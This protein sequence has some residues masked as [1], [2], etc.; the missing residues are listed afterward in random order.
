MN[1]QTFPQ[2]QSPNPQLISPGPNG[3][4]DHAHD[5]HVIVQIPCLNEADTLPVV[6]ADLPRA[7]PGV[8]RLETLVIDDG[9]TDNTVA[10]ARE[11]GVTYI[12]QHETN[13]GLAAAFQTGLDAS[14]KA[15]ADIII[16]TDGDNQYPGSKI[17]ELIRPIA[18][19]RADMVVGDRQTAGIIHFS[20]FK[21]FLQG[22]GSWVVRQASGTQVPDA[23]SGFRA[24]SREA[25]LRL[26]VL[27]RY[28][29]TAELIIQA[30]KKNLR[31]AHIPVAVNDPLRESRLLKNNWT[32]V[33]RQAATILR[34]YALYEPLRS[35]CYL[36]LPFLLTG[37]FLI[38]RFLY[39]YM[40]NQTY[41]GRHIQSVVIGGTL[42][43][44]GFFISLFGVMA[45]ITAMNR[46][47]LE[48]VLYR[49]RKRE[50][51]ETTGK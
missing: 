37:T 18:E 20:P 5:L 39:F 50:L 22:L 29:Y 11:L 42:L 6:L 38:G 49:Q 24:F 10:V 31:I 13:R 4:H 1:A 35:F 41:A 32:F 25:A 15:G 40:T 26:I 28:T 21:R 45:D 16:N 3:Y 19:G 44:V 51:S 47:I 27:T 48:E 17:A 23:T 33:K 2:T 30:G 36:A 14:L 12:V 8:A 43:T 34:I 46:Q 7:L 9:S